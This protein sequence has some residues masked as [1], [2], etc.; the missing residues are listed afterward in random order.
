MSTPAGRDGPE[1]TVE[2][3]NVVFV[4][5][6]DGS[7]QVL[8]D[9][10]DDGRLMNHALEDCV[11]SLPPRGWPGNGPCTYWIDVTEQGLADAIAT[12][13]NQ[14]FIGGNI[15]LFRLVGGRV[16]AR[17]DFDDIDDET[18][19]SEFIEIDD[20][21]AILQQWRELIVVNAASATAPLGA[22]G[23]RNPAGQTWF[24]KPGE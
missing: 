13:S 3:M 6:P 21:R 14:P 8:V 18:A 10:G 19:E 20:F 1:D 4:E 7:V 16:E 11:S 24:W 17:Y 2:C 12:G 23:R 5:N 9:L 15:T 22:S